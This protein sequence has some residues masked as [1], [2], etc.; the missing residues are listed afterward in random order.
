MD[1]FDE[2]T[3]GGSCSLTAEEDNASLSL[4]P[5]APVDSVIK[6]MDPIFSKTL[7]N[8]SIDE[9]YKAGWSED[10]PLYG[11]WLERKGSYDLTV[12]NWETST[13]GGF[14]NPWSKE[15]FPQKRV[16]DSYLYHIIRYITFLILVAFCD[17]SRLCDSNSSGLPIFT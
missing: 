16:R 6:T 1:D 10:P 7:N 5:D 9:Y 2:D 4:L 12:S 8:V 11:P 14:E 15:K 3:I 17:I 13:E